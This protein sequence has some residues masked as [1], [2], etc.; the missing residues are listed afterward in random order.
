MYKRILLPTDGSKNSE[1]AIKHAC[2]MATHE[3]AEIVV[4]N[5]IDSKHLTSLPEDAL[6]DDTEFVFE[7]HGDVVTK[8][9]EELI[10]ETDEN[11]KVSSITAEG[12]P[13]TAIIKAAEKE[14]MDV[15]VIA[16][17]GKHIL[18]RF[19]LG[20]VTSKTIKYSTIPVLVIPTNSE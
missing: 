14:N 19:L 4:I 7:E 16:S 2:N 11:I 20:S 9:V 12:D 6:D 1:K 18:D 13:A 15:I 17:S 10:K 5:V 3:H 8:H